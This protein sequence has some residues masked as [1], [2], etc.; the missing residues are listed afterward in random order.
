MNDDS[1]FHSR[2]RHRIFHPSK[3]SVISLQ[4]PSLLF[5]PERKYGL[6]FL[7]RIIV[8]NEW[9]YASNL[10]YVFMA[11]KKATLPSLVLDKKC[12]AV[13]TS[14]RYFWSIRA[15]PKSTASAD[16]NTCC[17]RSV[18]HSRAKW[19]VPTVKTFERKPRV[20]VL[21]CITRATVCQ[22]RCNR[23]VTGS[24]CISSG[25][26]NRTGLGTHLALVTKPRD[27]FCNPV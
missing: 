24:L 1:W 15:D 4:S 25:H 26:C 9:I 19:V 11:C 10:S 13:K 12:L 3:A 18:C 17:V 27:W 22:R 16:I 8:T 2:L 7:S 6:S 23:A 14:L 21:P 20:T 5:A